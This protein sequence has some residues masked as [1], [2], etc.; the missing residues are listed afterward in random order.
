MSVDVPATVTFVFVTTFTSGPNNILSASMGAV[1]GFRRTAP[2][3]L[4]VVTGLLAIMLGCATL[5]SVLSRVLPAA[6][7]VIRF[8]G[9]AYILW[10]AWGVY[11]TCS[12]FLASGHEA[13]PLRFWNGMV[14]QLVNPK[15]ALF[16]LTV[17]SVFLVAILND[18][19]TF[20]WSTLALLTTFTGRVPP[21][22]LTALAFSVASVIGLVYW[23]RQGGRLRTFVDLP[24]QIWL[25]GICGLFGYHFFYFLALRNAPAVEASLI[26]YLWP[27]LIVLLSSVLPGEKLRWFHVVDLLECCRAGG[28][29]CRRPPSAVSA[30]PRQSWRGSAMA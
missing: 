18:A 2:F 23:L 16:G 12:R 27:L 29:E 22:Q 5:S 15:A 10:L 20:I 1:F 4:G 14:L 26:A 24:W 25:L 13:R 3:L 28:V 6:A 19:M 21:F 7:P 11:R 8:V 9:A 17:Y 30:E